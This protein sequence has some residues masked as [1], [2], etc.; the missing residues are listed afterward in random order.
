MKK[1]DEVL[2]DCIHARTPKEGQV[3]SIT[4]VQYEEMELCP[5][6]TVFEFVIKTLS[7]RQDL[8]EDHTLFCNNIASDEKKTY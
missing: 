8:P 6:K 5:V 2:S 4:L 3:K 7:L 1:N